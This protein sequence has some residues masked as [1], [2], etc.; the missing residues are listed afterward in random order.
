MADSF[1][2]YN[3][4]NRYLL[5]RFGCVVRRLPVDLGRGCPHRLKNPPGCLFCNDEAIC[6]AYLDPQA[7][8]RAQ[9]DQGTVKY[10][11]ALFMPYLQAGANTDGTIEELTAIYRLCLSYPR[12]VG[13]I[14]ATRP[15][16]CPPEIIDLLDK[17]NQQTFL[18]VELG[19]QSANDRT[20]KR[21]NRGHDFSCYRQTTAALNRCHI[22]H[23]VHLILGL[24]EEDEAMMAN[25]VHQVLDCG[26]KAIK[27]HHLQ[28][29]KNTPLATEWQA[30][31]LTL[32]EEKTY[33]ELVCNLLE[34]I[35]WD[36]H[37]MRLLTNTNSRQRLAPNW[38]KS[39]DQMLQAI[40]GEF[41]RRG[42]R[43]G[44]RILLS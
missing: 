17:I 14:I 7:D 15:D 34:R 16:Y 12:V 18:I 8:I 6:P 40:T 30:G 36:I 23:A 39:K 25:S 20:L 43:Q 38:Q 19:L 42:T 31:K 41:A 21:I 4:F 9:L 26:T 13:L 33:P 32:L 5:D 28:V 44:S 2:P 35:P 37:I 10:P 27:F 22:Y 3:S 29:L 1:I 11:K 24:P